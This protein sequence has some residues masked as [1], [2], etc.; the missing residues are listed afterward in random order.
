MFSNFFRFRAIPAEIKSAVSAR[1]SCTTSVF[2]NR[3]FALRTLFGKKELIN[4][5]SCFFEF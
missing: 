2:L 3:N 4:R 1:H 5:R